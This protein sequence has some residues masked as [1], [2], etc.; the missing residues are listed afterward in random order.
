MDIYEEIVRLKRDGRTSAIAT[1]VQCIGSAP[2]KEGAKM[3]V[4]DDGSIMGTLG[5]GC[6]EAEVIQLAL[7][8]IREG[9][10]RTVPMDLTE[11]DGGLV[12]GGKIIVYIEP[13]IPEP[14]LVVLGAGHVGKALSSVAEIA[15]FRVTVVDDREEYANRENLPKAHSVV[16]A[17]FAT[18]FS[19]VAADKKAFVV[20]ATRGHNHD[21]EAVKASLGTE[22]P[23]IG[24]VGSRRKRQL[25]FRSLSEAGFSDKEIGRVIIPVGLP[26]GAVTPEEIAISIM[27]QIIEKRRADLPSE[28]GR[29]SCSDLI[30]NEKDQKNLSHR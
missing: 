25:L 1:I 22:A 19:S 30:M 21:L 3:L 15:G 17:D 24:L 16:V 14:H 8:A 13:V 6:I 9:A 28:V 27:A 4:R 5:G 10:P 18:T 2:R 7:M 26:I 29:S 20:I 23:Y 12:C 11:K